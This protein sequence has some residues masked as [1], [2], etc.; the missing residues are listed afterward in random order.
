MQKN[1]DFTV[2]SIN[3]ICLDDDARVFWDVLALQICCLFFSLLCL[4]LYDRLNL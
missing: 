4:L 2:W 1:L 3:M